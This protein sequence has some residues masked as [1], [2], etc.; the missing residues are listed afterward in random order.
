MRQTPGSNP[1]DS[2]SGYTQQLTA[3]IEEHFALAEQRVDTV[4]QL[5]FASVRQVSA[6]H[7]RHRTDIPQDLL[8]L[9][10]S[11]AAIVL[12][13]Q[14]SQRLS[15]KQQALQQ[16]LRD[17]L[18]DLKGLDERIQAYC[19]EV[20]MRHQ[21]HE[22]NLIPLS[23]TQKHDYENYV[24]HQLQRLHLPADGLREGLVAVTLMLTGRMLGDKALLSSAASIGGTLAGSA[25]ISQQSWWGGVWAGWFGVP[26]WVTW[27]GVGGGIASLLLLSPLLAPGVEWAVNRLRA[28]RLLLQTVHQA[29]DQLLTPDNLITLGK[30]GLYLQLLP[31][32]AQYL[33]RLRG[34]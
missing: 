17:D 18:L 31:D 13:K 30:L 33:A 9:P 32:L 22:E 6:R 1:S 3:L 4:Y 20:L 29:R 24:R 23:E 12:R 5:H 28:R 7:W 2:A 10:R 25:Y 11:L 21:L 15:G 19:D 8:L 16:I 27:A 14:Y 34:G 26:G